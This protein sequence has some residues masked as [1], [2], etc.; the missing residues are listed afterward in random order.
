[1]PER[2]RLLD[3]E[4]HALLRRRRLAHPHA[5]KVLDPAPARQQLLQQNKNTAMQ[6][7]ADK[8]KKDFSG[9]VHYQAGYGPP[10]TTTS[11]VKTTTT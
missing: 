9:K 7:W 10:A 3:G 4:R 5:P 1:M 2:G 8:V 11:T 6:T